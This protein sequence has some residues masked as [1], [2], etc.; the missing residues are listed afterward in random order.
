MGFEGVA[1]TPDSKAVVLSF[2]S[3]ERG[4]LFKIPYRKLDTTE[5]GQGLV[6]ESID[7]ELQLK[8]FLGDE[9]LSGLCFFDHD[10]ATYLAVLQRNA[11]CI[12]LLKLAKGRFIFVR[13][14]DLELRAPS[15]DGRGIRIHS[16]SPEGIACDGGR[17]VIVGDPY[18]K[19]YKADSQHIL[20]LDFL[21]PLVFD[22]DAD[23]LFK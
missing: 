15:P 22:F 20:E 2:A 17:M 3:G 13:R 8:P 16:A 11:S 4:Q 10:Q 6:P 21:V 12:H 9:A 18:H 14:V 23:E 5:V 19:V 1:I 7:V